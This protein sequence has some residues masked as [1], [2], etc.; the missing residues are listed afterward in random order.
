[1][2]DPFGGR[3]DARL[4]GPGFRIV[5]QLPGGACAGASADH[6]RAILSVAVEQLWNG[7]LSS[8]YAWTVVLDP[9]TSAKITR[10][11]PKS[12]P[13]VWA[14]VAPLVRSIVSAAVTAVPYDAERLLH[15]VGRLALWAEAAGMSGINLHILFTRQQA[16]GTRDTATTHEVIASITGPAAQ[17]PDTASLPPPNGPK[18]RTPT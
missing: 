3:V 10:Y 16:T 1:M 6:A 14:Q 11:R 17:P 4:F 7:C 15:V 2:A 8:R 12:V 9:V 5:G 18:I 13:P